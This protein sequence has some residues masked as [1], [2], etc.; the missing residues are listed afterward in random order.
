[1][2]GGAESRERG[3]VSVQVKGDGEDVSVKKAERGGSQQGKAADAEGSGSKSAS[4]ASGGAGG[5]EGKLLREASAAQ[6][7]GP[8]GREAETGQGGSQQG[9][10]GGGSGSGVGASDGR[11]PKSGD[12][13]EPLF[14]QAR[15]RGDGDDADVRDE[16]KGERREEAAHGADAA[17]Q[18]SLQSEKTPRTSPRVSSASPGAREGGADRG[19]GGGAQV[20]QAAGDSFAQKNA[21][22]GGAG[23]DA[24]SKPPPVSRTA[25]GNLKMPSAT[26]PDAVCPRDSTLFGN[27]DRDARGAL[28]PRASVSRTSSAGGGGGNLSRT[29]SYADQ[30]HSQSMASNMLMKVFPSLFHTACLCLAHFLLG[31]LVLLS[32]AIR[33]DKARDS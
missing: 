2:D 17:F 21:S 10:A 28:S 30:Q 4:G 3:G 24:Q 13:R 20:G 9:R 27:E 6:D 22:R 14:E 29:A 33:Q 8:R 26:N 1:M 7:A 23:S 19:R 12:G 25:S 16:G 15:V 18:G 31:M 5:A 11:K 32:L